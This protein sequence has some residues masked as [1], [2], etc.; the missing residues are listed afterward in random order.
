MRERQAIVAAIEVEDV[1]GR[2]PVV[3]FGVT[4]SAESSMEGQEQPADIRRPL[5]PVVAAAK[6]SQSAA[7]QSPSTV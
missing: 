4:G 2:G 5:R 3:L 7:R 1:V 6:R